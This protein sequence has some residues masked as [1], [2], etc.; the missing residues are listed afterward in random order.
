MEIDRLSPGVEKP[1][2]K[3]LGHAIRN[4]FD[5]MNH[6]LDVISD[7][8]VTACLGMCAIVA[9]YAAIDIC[10]RRWPSDAS[11]REIANGASEGAKAEEF[12]L[13]PQ[14]VY[15]YLSRVALGFESLG[16]VFAQPEAAIT[17]SFV[18]T[19]HILGGYSITRQSRSG[20]ITWIESRMLSSKRKLR[21]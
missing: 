13:K 19:G 6:T 15:S 17:L 9:G 7:E 5:D 3:A 11:L 4:E 20:G 21:I 2:R 14:D 1:F 10:R 16:E 12:G 8:Q 18:I